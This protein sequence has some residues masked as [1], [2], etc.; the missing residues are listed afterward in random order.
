MNMCLQY[1]TMEKGTPDFPIGLFSQT[2]YYSFP[3]HHI[4]YELFYVDEGECI[5][6]V[7]NTEYTLKAGSVLFIQPGIEH[8]AKPVNESSIF[9]YHAFVFDVSVFGNEND[10]CRKIFEH[11]KIKRF[12]NLP[13]ELLDKMK[14]MTELQKDMAF[15]RQIQ[16]KSV[17]LEIIAYIIDSK[18]Y[19]EID[20]HVNP[21]TQNV[22]KKTNSSHAV[23]AAILF[24]QQHYREN[25][26]LED[27]LSITNYCKSHFIRVF[28]STTG[29]KFTDYV[30]HYRIE[31]SCL[32]LI[33][34]DKNIT[35]IAIENGFNNIQYFSKTFKDYMRCTP[36][37]YKKIGMSVV[38]PSTIANVV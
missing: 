34:T 14:Y 38:V 18:Q 9:H 12:L 10:A 2:I 11:M 32:D 8:Y 7:E 24:I 37:Q 28:K 13:T 17:L 16:V 29:L 26:C 6:G 36:M 23:D 15:G 3:H 30:N 4:E 19:L 22:Q 1:E 31:K 5:F 21:V 27:L 35:E 25:I 20:N 33:Y